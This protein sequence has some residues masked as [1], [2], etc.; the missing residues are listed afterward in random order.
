MLAVDADNTAALPVYRASGMDDSGSI[1]EWCNGC[2]H[3][4]TLSL[5]MANCFRFRSGRFAD[6]QVSSF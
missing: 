2:E 5:T 4:Y 1:L 3:R 6:S